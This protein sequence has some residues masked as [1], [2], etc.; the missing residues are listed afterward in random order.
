MGS[1]VEP[2]EYVDTGQCDVSFRGRSFLSWTGLSQNR[3]QEAYV[4][5]HG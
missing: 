5:V 3:S 2:A 4:I 1:Y